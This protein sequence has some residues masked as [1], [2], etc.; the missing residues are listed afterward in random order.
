MKIHHFIIIFT[1]YASLCSRHNCASSKPRPYKSGPASLQRTECRQQFLGIKMT[2]TW[3]WT[4][5]YVTILQYYTEGVGDN[6]PRPL[7]STSML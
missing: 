2:G 4:T 1:N 3:R 5:K 6:F 7:Y